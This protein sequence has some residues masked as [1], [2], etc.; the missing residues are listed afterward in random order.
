M[1]E[2]PKEV[3]SLG[4]KEANARNSE[5][6]KQGAGLACLEVSLILPSDLWCFSL[7]EPEAKEPR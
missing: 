5:L 2:E 6:K 4:G 7:A 3:W 1:I